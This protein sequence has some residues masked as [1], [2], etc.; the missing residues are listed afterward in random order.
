MWNLQ[1]EYNYLGT[2][3]FDWGN[4]QT[5]MGSNVLTRT[6]WAFGME[7]F[8]YLASTPVNIAQHELG[9]GAR[10]TAIGGTPYYQWSGSGSFSSIF[11][12]MIQGVLGFKSGLAYTHYASSSTTQ[13]TDYDASVG[14][15]GMNNSMMYAEAVED[16]VYFNTG[17]ILMY[18]SYLLGKL[19]PYHYSY[20]T[21]TGASNGGDVS[22]LLTYWS[23]K[24]YG[25]SY[26]NLETGSLL[27]AFGS[28]TNW[29][30]LW[31]I[32]KYLGTGD[33]TVHAP[34]FGGFKLPDFSS[35]QY[36]RGVSIRSRFAL[37]GGSQKRY[38]PIG[39]EYVFK[40]S[41]AAEVSF[42]IRDL[43][44][45]AGVLKTGSMWQ[46]FL[47]SAGGGGFRWSRDFLTG[48]HSFFTVGTS[49]FNDQSLEG[50][51]TAGHFFT[52]AIGGELWSKWTLT[53]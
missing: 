40:G 15:G 26:S 43:N 1:L 35:Y 44:P 18:P 42:G 45:M 53:Y 25:V 29:A 28:A 17:H 33:P 13:P 46:V 6:L 27:S 38:Y 5:F 39:V 36:R 9:H 31:S 8:W 7:A 16:E 22:S 32:L 3:L 11:P 37:G 47:S 12:F 41:P 52:K 24:G 4:D 20:H 30:F 50:E 19:D 51:R 21:R 49:L 14:M 10:A 34:V 23:G 48:I 2:G